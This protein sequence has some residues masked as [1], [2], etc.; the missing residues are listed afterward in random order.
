MN[1]KTA[2][3]RIMD[4][5][6]WNEFCDAI[7]MAGSIITGRGAP[8]DPLIRA[9]GFRYPGRLARG[10]LEAF[11]EYNDPLAPVLFRPVHETVKMGADN[12]DNYYQWAS[13]SGAHA[14]RLEERRDRRR[15]LGPDVDLAERHA[16]RQQM[17]VRVAEAGHREPAVELDDARAG[18]FEALEVGLAS[19][20]R[21]A[22][23]AHR[24]R[25]AEAAIGAAPDAPAPEDQIGLRVAH[26]H[27]SP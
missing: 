10:A 18:P 1:D 12:P 8:D 11:V 9:E 26:L 5:G 19:R 24:Q 16:E 2:E 14:Y 23:A 3:Q 22:V 13:I 20:H 4:A 21:D 17:H 6:A 15:R 25:L 27:V 7:K